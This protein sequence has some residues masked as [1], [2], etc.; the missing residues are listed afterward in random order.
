MARV[1]V[2]VE[3]G[4]RK[5]TVER[6]DI[7]ELQVVAVAK[8]LERRM[9]ELQSRTGIV[10][11]SRLAIMTALDVA[12]DMTKVQGRLDEGDVVHE[13]RLEGMIMALE[14]A[15]APKP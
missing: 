13:R 9:A 5:F 14:K 6:D 4:R 8:D 3:V 7:D 10:D 1:K 11:T 15:L 12:C 2:D